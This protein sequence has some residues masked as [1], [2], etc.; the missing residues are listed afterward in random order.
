MAVD[1]ATV[2]TE[3]AKAPVEEKPKGPAYDGVVKGKYEW[4]QDAEG[5]KDADAD[6]VHGDAITK[7]G[8]SDGKKVVSVYIELPGLDDVAEDAITVSHEANKVSCTI[9]A[10]GSPPKKRSLTLNGLANEIE[11]VKLVCKKGKNTIVLKLQKKEEKSWW[12]LLDQSSGGGGGDDDDAEGMG[13]MGG[14]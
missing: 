10:I 8:W 5:K 14:M 1:E 13:G 12:K 11:G 4:G 9:A 7:Y 2:A 3:E 6:M